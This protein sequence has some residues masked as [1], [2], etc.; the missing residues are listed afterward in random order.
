MLLKLHTVLSPMKRYYTFKDHQSLQEELRLMRKSLKQ[1]ELDL[2]EDTK[3]ALIA[4]PSNVFNRPTQNQKIVGGIPLVNNAT[5]KVLAKLANSTILKK[6]GFITKF[7]A[8]FFLKRLGK[9]VENTILQTSKQ[10]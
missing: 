10:L 1:S 6:Q 7:V 9:K 8:G 5:G 4:L 3:K 2:K